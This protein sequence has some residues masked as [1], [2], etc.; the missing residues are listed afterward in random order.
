MLSAH[1]HHLLER[2]AVGSRQRLARDRSAAPARLEPVLAYL[3]DHLFDRGLRVER[4]KQVFGVRDG[5]LATHFRAA[6]GR[7]ALEYIRDR[8]CETAGL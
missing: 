8:R 1:G 7:T 5:S 3:A 6:C 2:A 4:L